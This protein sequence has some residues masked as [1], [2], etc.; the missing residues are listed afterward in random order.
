MTKASENI[1]GKN[2]HAS[3]QP[4]SAE[5]S[6]NVNKKKKSIMLS[7]LIL[8]AWD[9]SMYLLHSRGTHLSQNNANEY[10]ILA[11]KILVDNKF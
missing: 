8:N 6:I 2:A 11:T 7:T 9:E 4:F 10:T 5:L 3:P 1:L